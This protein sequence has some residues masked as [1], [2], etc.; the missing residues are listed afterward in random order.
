MLGVNKVESKLNQL[1]AELLR[2]SANEI[3]DTLSMKDTDAW[4]SLKHMELIVSIE[5]TFDIQL[6]ADEIVTMLDVKEI[7][8]IL[9]KKG[10]LN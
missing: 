3:T 7:K 1:L 9:T 5:E 8:N 4:D 6:T 2:L 10:A